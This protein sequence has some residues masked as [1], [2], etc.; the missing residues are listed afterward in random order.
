M[1]VIYNIYYIQWK[2]LQAKIKNT[3]G[4]TWTEHALK[5]CVLNLWSKD[6]LIGHKETDFCDPRYTAL[7]NYAKQHLPNNSQIQVQN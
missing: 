1:C 6:K 4:Q 7:L 5:T 2:E 3:L